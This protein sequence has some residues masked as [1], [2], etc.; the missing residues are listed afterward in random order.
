MT[1]HF[2]HWEQHGEPEQSDW[3]TADLQWA[4]HTMRERF[5]M[6]MPSGLFTLVGTR[7]EPDWHLEIVGYFS[8]EEPLTLRFYPQQETVAL[9]GTCPRCGRQYQHGDLKEFR[10]LE[11]LARHW[12][13]LGWLCGPCEYET[14]TERIG[15]P[16]S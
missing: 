5:E 10:Q 12:A 6:E 2:Q 4:F 16:S 1:Q 9:A 13:A 7:G 8:G 11:N 15:G 3:W 14:L